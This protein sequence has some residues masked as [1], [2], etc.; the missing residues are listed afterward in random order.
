MRVCEDLLWTDPSI[1]LPEDRSLLCVDFESLGNSP[2]IMRQLWISEMEA[3]TAAARVESAR[4]EDVMW[5]NDQLVV[6]IDTEGSIR[7]R[8]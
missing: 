6:P 5:E 2:A 8:R 3:S 1:L 4:Q 7:F